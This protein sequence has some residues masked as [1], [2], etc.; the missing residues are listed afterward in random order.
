MAI[1]RPLDTNVVDITG[2]DLASDIAI[3]T[4]GNIATTGSGTLTVAGAFTASGGI[5]N[6]GTITAGTLGSS[7][8]F[9]NGHILQVKQGV[10]TDTSVLTSTSFVDIGLSVAIT[11]A[12]TSNK[13]L[14]NVQLFGYA[15]HYVSYNR[16]MR[17]STELGKPTSPSNRPD[18]ALSF[19]QPPDLD[20]AIAHCAVT[21]LDSPSTTSAVTYKVQ[22]A[23][24]A[25]GT[26]SAYINRSESDRDDTTYDP[27]FCSYITVMEV[28]A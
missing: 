26:Q 18:H 11:P 9:P 8:V 21:I 28:V 19:S 12:D 23:E 3:S 20:G 24:R 6:S 1:R 4:T 5:A 25:D 14:V 15:G 2:A 13:I 27:R 17:D 16:V 22:S 7:V 10:K